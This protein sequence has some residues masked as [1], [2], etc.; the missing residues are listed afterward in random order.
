MNSFFSLINFLLGPV[1]LVLRRNYIPM[2]SFAIAKQTRASMANA[3]DQFALLLATPNVYAS[4]T[5]TDVVRNRKTN[6]VTC[7]VNK[8]N[9]QRVYQLFAMNF[10]ALT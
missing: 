2:G 4:K 8:L 3:R 6:D 7:V 10:N 9:L 5:K 1:R